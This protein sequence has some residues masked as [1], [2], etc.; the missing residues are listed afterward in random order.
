MLNSVSHR[1]PVIESVTYGLIIVAVPSSMPVLVS[2]L[3][4]LKVGHT[5][6]HGEVVKRITVKPAVMR[7]EVVLAP[8][9]SV[10]TRLQSGH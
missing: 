9:I 5:A 8:F 10:T 6:G 4:T 7:T 2:G 1:P 3:I